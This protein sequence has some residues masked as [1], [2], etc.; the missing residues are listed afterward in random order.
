MSIYGLTDKELDII[1][2]SYDDY[3]HNFEMRLM[4]D[5]ALSQL[6]KQDNFILRT[7]MPFSQYL[8]KL[9]YLQSL[10]KFG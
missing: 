10:S 9:L 2:Q 5:L 1:W 8:N 6:K 3:K 7:R 4:S